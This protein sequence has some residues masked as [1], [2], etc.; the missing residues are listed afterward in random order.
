MSSFHCLLVIMIIFVMDCNTYVCISS[1][2]MTFLIFFFI[3]FSFSCWIV[4]MMCL[5]IALSSSRPSFP[6]FWSWGSLPS[7]GLVYA[8][9]FWFSRVVLYFCSSHNQ[10]NTLHY[11]WGLVCH[12]HWSCLPLFLYDSWRHK[13]FLVVVALTWYL[14][15]WWSNIE[16][17]HFCKTWPQSLEIY[18]S[19]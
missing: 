19:L 11:F 18:V 13:V 10:S 14:L 16:I 8:F 3:F 15:D 5:C 6:S 12:C 1:P 9:V 2:A 7:L 17:D 4:V